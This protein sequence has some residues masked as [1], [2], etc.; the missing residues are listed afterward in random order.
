MRPEPPAGIRLV[1]DDGRDLL[2]VYRASGAEWE[3]PAL[4][5]ELDAEARALAVTDRAVGAILVG[6]DRLTDEAYSV[7][8]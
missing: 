7:D 5:D 2:E 4:P 6:T 1:P 3:A 8:L